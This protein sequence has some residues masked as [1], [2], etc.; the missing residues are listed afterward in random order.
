[1]TTPTTDMAEMAA[2]RANVYGLLADVYREEPSESF[3]SGLGEPDIATALN[4]LGLSLGAVLKETPRA[5]LVEDL[6]LEYTRLFIGP[7]SHISPNESMHVDARFGEANELWG[8]RT[9]A[10]KKFMEGAGVAV[11]DDFP[12]MPDHITAEFEFM[13]RLLEKEAEAWADGADELAGNILKIENRFYEEHLSQWVCRFCERVG[14]AAEH[15]F[16]KQFADVTRGFIR[17]E[18][19]NLGQMLQGLEESGRLTA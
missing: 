11:R 12:G 6:A 8:E 1:M 16:Y 4:A 5:K 7:G 13:Q 9:V 3:L 15:A 17:F 14:E 19:E 2:A 18:G 10:V